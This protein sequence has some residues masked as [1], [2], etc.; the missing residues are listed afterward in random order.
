MKRYKGTLPPNRSSIRRWILASLSLLVTVGGPA[1]ANT[2]LLSEEHMSAICRADVIMVGESYHGL[3]AYSDSRAEFAL[4]IARRCS[5]KNIAFEGSAYEFAELERHKRASPLTIQKVSSAL[6]PSASGSRGI[7][8]F[9]AALLP[10]VTSGKIG[11]F[12]L[13]FQTGILGQSFSNIEL[14]QAVARA[15]PQKD[16]H[17][18]LMQMNGPMQGVGNIDP[19]LITKC[20]TRFGRATRGTGNTVYLNNLRLL[21]NARAG[22][23]QLFTSSRNSAMV[24]NFDR[25]LKLRPGKTLVLAHNSHVSYGTP[26]RRY[27]SSAGNLGFA[28]RHAGKGTYAIATTIRGGRYLNWQGTPVDVVELGTGSLE[29]SQDCKLSG[30]YLTGAAFSNLGRRVSIIDNLQPTVYD[31]STVFDAVYTVC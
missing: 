4:N 30:T 29:T 3:Q 23:P 18:C 27:G 25:M 1:A 14:S 20:L 2:P 24:W 11:L 31:W 6:G 17:S 10:A 12:G 28:I 22:D 21:A 9:I 19:P 5:I 13:D 15:N 26:W 7:E 8:R 16:R